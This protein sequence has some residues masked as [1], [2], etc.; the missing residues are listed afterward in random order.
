MA[1][2]AR[3]SGIVSR[4]RGEFTKRLIGEPQPRDRRPMASIRIIST[5]G[6]N[7]RSRKTA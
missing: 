3:Q 5:S 7:G 1:G 4:V 2:E 6:R